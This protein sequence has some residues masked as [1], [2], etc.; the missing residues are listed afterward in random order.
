MTVELE[1]LMQHAV[2]FV[3]Q[4]A[5]LAWAAPFHPTAFIGTIRCAVALGGD[6]GRRSGEGAPGPPEPIGAA[7]AFDSSMVLIMSCLKR[8]EVRCERPLVAVEIL[9]RAPCV[10]EHHAEHGREE[11]HRKRGRAEALFDRQRLLARPVVRVDDGLRLGVRIEDLR[12]LAQHRGSARLDGLLGVRL[13]LA[14]LGRAV[15]RD[16]RV[17]SY[18]TAYYGV[19]RRGE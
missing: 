1:H 16:E 7:E 18:A 15:R 13:R 8:C 17:A 5:H 9:G 10:D 3:P 19:Y 14:R 6:F 12:A 4:T 2:V 11:A